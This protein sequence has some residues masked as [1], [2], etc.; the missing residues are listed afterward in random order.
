MNLNVTAG[1]K[2]TLSKSFCYFPIQLNE[3]LILFF[4]WQQTFIPIRGYEK[5]KHEKRME[6]KIIRKIEK[7]EC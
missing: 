6:G 5:K 7:S 4:S 1:G 2:T 3:A